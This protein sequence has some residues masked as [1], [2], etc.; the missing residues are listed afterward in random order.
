MSKKRVGTKTT[1]VGYLARNRPYSNINTLSLAILEQR[2]QKQKKINLSSIHQNHIELICRCGHVGIVAVA[3]LIEVFGG[4]R[5]W[6][7]I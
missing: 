3:D 6:Q 2:E 4:G 5:R 1:C 7:I